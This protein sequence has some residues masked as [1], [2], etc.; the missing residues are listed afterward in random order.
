MSQHVVPIK[1]YVGV[2]VALLIL[3]GLTTRIAFINLGPMNTVVALAIAVLKMLLVILIF[4]HVRRSSGLT[5]IVIVAGFFWLALLI[6]MTYTDEHTRQW[7]PTPSGW[8]SSAAT[9]P[10]R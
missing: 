9:V 5:K 4:M 2:F 10:N 7:S 6:S 1:N 8:D 3:T